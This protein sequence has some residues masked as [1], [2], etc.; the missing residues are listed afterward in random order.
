MAPVDSG[1]LGLSTNGHEVSNLNGFPAAAHELG[2][3]RR[4][5]PESAIGRA[6]FRIVLHCLGIRTRRSW[7]WRERGRPKPVLVISRRDGTL[8]F[9]TRP[10]GGIGRHA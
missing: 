9:A 7:G 5:Y 1:F 3:D 6:V 2:P 4:A 10:D 8:A